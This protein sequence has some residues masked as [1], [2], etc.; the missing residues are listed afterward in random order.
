MSSDRDSV[1]SF[2]LCLKPHNG[3]FNPTNLQLEFDFHLTCACGNPAS[4]PPKAKSLWEKQALCSM[5]LLCPS[6]P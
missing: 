1:T 6:L 4:L 3:D 2:I 5:G